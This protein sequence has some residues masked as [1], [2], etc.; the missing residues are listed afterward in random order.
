M[1]YLMVAVPVDVGLTVWVKFVPE[2]VIPL[3][4][5]ATTSQNEVSFFEALGVEPVNV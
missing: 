3:V 1:M 5:P 2:A 4:A